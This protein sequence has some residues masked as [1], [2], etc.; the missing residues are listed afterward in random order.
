MQS[1][2]QYNGIECHETKKC[3]YS[4]FI[5]CYVSTNYEEN[6][7]IG[8]VLRE[9]PSEEHSTVDTVFCSVDESKGSFIRRPQQTES[10]GLNFTTGGAPGTASP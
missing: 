3:F 5:P 4:M 7:I 9:T 6:T 1:I 10:R 2:F 8:V